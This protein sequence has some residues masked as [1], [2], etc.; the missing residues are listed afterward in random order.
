MAP[1]RHKFPN[2]LLIPAL[3]DRI[4]SF[5]NVIGFLRFELRYD[6]RNAPLAEGAFNIVQM[7]LDRSV[8]HLAAQR[9]LSR[10]L[11]ERTAASKRFQ[12]VPCNGAMR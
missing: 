2:K 6:R 1:L 4:G 9:R 11:S 3:L 7:E 8:A 5:D 10:L 12:I